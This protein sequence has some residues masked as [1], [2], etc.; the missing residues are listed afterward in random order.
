MIKKINIIRIVFF[1]PLLYVAFKIRNGGVEY[2]VYFTSL[3]L[4]VNILGW[5]L[6]KKKIDRTILCEYYINSVYFGAVIAILINSILFYKGF[7]YI[8]TLVMLNVVYAPLWL[9]YERRRKLK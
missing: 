8:V 3:T 1:I 4:M 2:L 7:V 9:Y 6:I 5:F